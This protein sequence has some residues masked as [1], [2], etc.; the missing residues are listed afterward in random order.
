[1]T[2][3]CSV[4]FNPIKEETLVFESVWHDTGN[5]HCRDGLVN[6]RTENYISQHERGLAL[7]LHLSVGSYL[8]VILQGL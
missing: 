3:V 6:G 2:E 8:I 7:D 1:M 5:T 4:V